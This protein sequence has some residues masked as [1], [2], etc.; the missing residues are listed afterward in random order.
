MNTFDAAPVL[1]AWEFAAK[2]H[3]GSF[4]ADGKTEYITHP[5]EVAAMV[6]GF[7]CDTDTVVASLLHD[8]VEDAGVD[9]DTL[10]EEFGER[11]A[12]IVAELTFPDGITDRAG[13]MLAAVP[14]M[15][16]E[17]AAIKL[18]DCI[19]NLGDLAKSGWAPERIEKHRW[20]KMTLA[21][22]LVKRLTS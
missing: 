6:A 20:R 7:G 5:T 18:A 13:T 19:C 2:A 21:A 9:I 12:G 1:K 8:T 11:A 14:T 15:S 4:R 22:A 16:R 17:A 3:A 10:V